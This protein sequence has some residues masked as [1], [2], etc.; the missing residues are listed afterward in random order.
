MLSYQHAYHAGNLADVHKHAA[1]AW[2]CD[3][4]TRKDKPLSYIETHAGR[5]LYD[6][7]ARRGR[8]DRRGPRRA[9]GAPPRGSTPGH[10]YSRA[11][12]QIADAQGPHAYPRFAAHRPH[13]AA[14]HRQP[15]SG[16]VASAGERSP[17]QRAEGTERAYPPA[18]RLCP[19]AKPL[20]ADAAPGPDA[21]RHPSWEVKED[22]AS[23]PKILQQIH[24]KWNVG[25]LMLW[26][27][28]L[29]DANAPPDDA[30]AGPRLPRG[31]VA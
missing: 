5:G 21:D 4:L 18:G 8:Q 12:A 20:S 2:V 31:A 9:S 10:P 24:A 14:R 27:P 25:I 17:A 30:G 22:Y 19:C 7:S 3:Y 6:L 28:I 16:R 29:S 11:R 26:Y 15:A 13:A 1:L 23:V